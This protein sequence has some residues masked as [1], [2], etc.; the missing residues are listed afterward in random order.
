[1]VVGTLGDSRY[2]GREVLKDTFLVDSVCGFGCTVI[3]RLSI[4]VVNWPVLV[5]W[6]LV[7]LV[8]SERLFV[9]KGQFGI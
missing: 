7:C 4:G 5:R 6:F 9:L 3:L 2:C 1:M 8:M